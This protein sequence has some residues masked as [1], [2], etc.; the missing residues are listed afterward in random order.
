MMTFQLGNRGVPCGHGQ[1]LGRNRAGACDVQ[2]G[3]A[4]H[5]DFFSA[6]RLSQQFGSPNLGDPS[7]LIP[8]LVIVPEATRAKVLPEMVMTQLDLRAEPYIPGQ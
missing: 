6:K 8:I 4:H 1:T 3:I 7:D 2:R 5:Q